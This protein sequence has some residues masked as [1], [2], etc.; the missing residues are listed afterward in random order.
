MPDEQEHNYRVRLTIGT[1]RVKSNKNIA[2][3][4]EALL[5]KTYGIVTGSTPIGE[6]IWV[7]DKNLIAIDEIDNTQATRSKINVG[8]RVEGDP[9]PLPTPP[10]VQ[11]PIDK[12]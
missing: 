2:D 4:R 12:D 7:T 6:Q 3:Y 10:S 9:L 8:A 1:Y 11:P 5:S